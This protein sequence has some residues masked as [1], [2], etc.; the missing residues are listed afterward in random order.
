MSSAFQVY[1]LLMKISRKIASQLIKIATL[2]IL[3][4]STR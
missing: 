3:S 1:G 2:L 4:I